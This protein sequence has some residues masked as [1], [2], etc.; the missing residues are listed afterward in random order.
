[1]NWQRYPREDCAAKYS[2]RHLAASQA[3]SKVAHS[4]P[5]LASPEALNTTQIF[6]EWLTFG[7]WREVAKST[8]VWSTVWMLGVRV[9]IFRRQES[10]KVVDWRTRVW[11]SCLPEKDAGVFERIRLWIQ[12]EGLESRWRDQPWG[13]GDFFLQ[14]GGKERSAC[15]QHLE[16]CRGAGINSVWRALGS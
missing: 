12:E 5:L 10:C 1:M 2:G 13:H 6:R 15:R 3:P 4:S 8:T 9:F 14:S 16:W 7:R 11:R